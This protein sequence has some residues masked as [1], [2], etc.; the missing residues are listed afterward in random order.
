MVGDLGNIEADETGKAVVNIT[1][2]VAKL[3]GPQSVI[4][5]SIVLHALQD[6]EGRGGYEQ[7]LTTGNTG[8]RIGA[9]VIGI[10]LE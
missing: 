2:Q 4:G 7:S 10:S 8:P 5:R 9:G 3:T 1:D 6:D